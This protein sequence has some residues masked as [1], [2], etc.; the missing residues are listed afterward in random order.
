MKIVLV[1][2][3]VIFAAATCASGQQSILT[4]DLLP[5]GLSLYQFA[6]G[7]SLG[8]VTSMGAVAV[9]YDRNL[10]DHLGVFVKL[11]YIHQ[12]SYL[13][14]SGSYESYLRLAE[15]LGILWR[16]AA[17]GS[18]WTIGL[19]LENANGLVFVTNNLASGDHGFV[20]L[21]VPLGYRFA[22]GDRCLVSAS[23]G[24]SFELTWHELLPGVSFLSNPVL[25]TLE[26][27]IG[28]VL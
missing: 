10:T 4:V 26:L 18:C 23:I 19:Q 22:I 27:G 17:S 15:R 13:P 6:V 1:L 2:V 21:G 9:R 16:S 25:E 8:N 24:W 12:S 3:V 28:F 20:G 11:E 7:A 5:L 14:S